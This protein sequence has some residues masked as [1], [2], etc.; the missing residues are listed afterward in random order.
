MT[1]I[2]NAEIGEPN[3]RV[4]VE[5]IQEPATPSFPATPVPAEP[6]P[7]KEPVPA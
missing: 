6:V 7:A 5:P 3:R 4:V 2:K 1:I